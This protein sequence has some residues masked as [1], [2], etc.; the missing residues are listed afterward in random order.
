MSSWNSTTPF[1]QWPGINCTGGV[2]VT[3]ISL[4]SQNVEGEIPSSIC[5][6]K[7][8][9]LLDLG[10]NNIIGNF[11]TFL[12]NCTMLQKLDLSQNYF[13]GK[14]PD[15]INKLPP[16]LQYLIISGNN[17]TGDI[18]PSLAQ[19]KGLIN[20]YLDSN[21]F[22]GTFPS[23]LGHLINLEELVLAYNPFARNNLPKEFG[24]LMN[25]KFLW[26]TECN[27]IGEIP[28]EFTNLTSLVHLDLVGNNLEGEIPSGLFLLKSLKKLYL[29]KNRLFG[30]MPTSIEA[31]NLVE[32]DVSQNNLTGI[33]PDDI[34]K[35]R[36]LEILNLFQNQ[37]HG[38]IPPS[39]GQLP[40]LKRLGLFMNQFRG[41]L[42]SE[43]GLHSKLES[44]EVSD[45]AFIGQLPENLGYNGDLSS[46]VAFNN[47]LNGTISTSQL[48]ANLIWLDI[49]NNKFSGPI[50]S[51]IAKCENLL[52]FKASNNQLW[53]KIPME[54]TALSSLYSLRLDGNQLSGE[55]PSSLS[56]WESLAILNISKNNLSGPLPA[57]LGS[58]PHLQ[59][60]DLSQNKL[61]GQIP[62][63][64]TQQISLQNLITLNLS[65][66]NLKGKIPREFDNKAFNLSFLNNANLCSDKQISR[67]P[68][69]FT[70]HHRYLVEILVPGAIIFLIFL[71]FTFF[72]INMGRHETHG[73]EQQAWELKPFHRIEF[74]EAVIV[75]S[76]TNNNLIGTGGS[77]KVYMAPVNDLGN[78]VAVKRIWNGRKL[79]DA[80]EKQFLTEVEFLGTLR[81]ANIVKL[82]CCVSS[83]QEKLLVYEY[84]ENQSL[85]KWLHKRRR[86][87]EPS[88]MNS[89]ASRSNLELYIVL[90][91]PT[92]LK[93]AVGAANGLCYLH[94]AC[95]PVIIHRDVKSSNI[96]LDSE[97]NAKIAD[98]GLA[99]VTI[100]AKGPHTAS[101]IA[102]SFGY[103][104]P[105]YWR[106]KR[107]D[108]KIDVYSFG[109]V[110]LELTTGKHPCKGNDHLNL[111]DWSW[112]HCCEEH[113]IT[114][115]LDEEIK[116]PRFIEQMVNVFKLGV[117]CT[118]Q[119][120]NSRPTMKQ[121]V[122]LLIKWSHDED[123]DQT[124]TTNEA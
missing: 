109:V 94:H 119:T 121:V 83:A 10:N 95:C 47:N 38:I 97:F 11:P 64:L 18:P 101:A 12:Y 114:D 124:Q 60:L 20:L 3:G 112:K 78:K 55:L 110:L 89:E 69:C 70:S 48:T 113:P 86:A 82:L 122:Q 31:L 96:L 115:A 92:R 28:K 37:F 22:N 106:T 49:S 72:K 17:F 105:E 74:T 117:M 77:G 111:A 52:V 53:G 14:L 41:S 29:Y 4:N 24:K 43:L 116:E 58:I 34:G 104:A 51:S 30:G 15:D 62:Y 99:K 67:L 33:I 32:L 40:S 63:K 66:N 102:G 35:L 81:H 57:A 54:L 123:H 6:L 65:S 5:D 9:T 73:S 2:T 21:L 108:E 46:I 88:S 118:S 103:I 13:V 39:I 56:S 75:S 120:P 7:N 27:L 76:L 1:C 100:K 79:E 19:L 8:L 59:I 71:C 50:P 68:P 44:F 80:L 61:S 23:E 36:K 42:P 26:M 90:D 84:M 25:L 91:W 107:L 16:T 87:N 85:D 98:F 93:I 45:N